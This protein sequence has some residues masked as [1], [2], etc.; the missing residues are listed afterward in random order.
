MTA[1]GFCHSSLIEYSDFGMAAFSCSL[2]GYAIAWPAR[3][4]RVR[5]ILSN[6]P[7]A[8]EANL[9]QLLRADEKL[10]AFMELEPTIAVIPSRGRN[11]TYL[12]PARSPNS[13]QHVQCRMACACPFF[14]SSNN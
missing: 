4:S 6:I 9:E 5:R 3:R 10:T 12:Q 14:T 1:P 8:R 13:S 11:L 7:R 2:S